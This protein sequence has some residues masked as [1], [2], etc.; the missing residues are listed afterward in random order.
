MPDRYK[1]VRVVLENTKERH[2]ELRVDFI[3]LD[4]RIKEGI[5]YFGMWQDRQEHF[6][7]PFVMSVDGEIDFGTGYDGEDRYYETNFMKKE[8]IVGQLVT[9][10]YG[11]EEL[12]FRVISL[13]P[14]LQ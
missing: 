6:R 10:S 1:L 4:G 7:C 8:M 9:Y 5:E 14:L 12:V 2:Q 11:S 13:T 3:L